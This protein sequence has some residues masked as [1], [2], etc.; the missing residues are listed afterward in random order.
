MVAIEQADRES[1]YERIDVIGYSLGGLIARDYVQRLGGEHRA[2]SLITLGTPYSG[3][4]ASPRW[5]SAAV[6]RQLAPGSE[7]LTSSP[8][9]A[10]HLFDPV[11]RRLQRPRPCRGAQ[12]ERPN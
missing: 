10:T 8:N 7:L 2:D 6:G 12:P 3:H 5:T 11:S 1:G 9:S 4:A